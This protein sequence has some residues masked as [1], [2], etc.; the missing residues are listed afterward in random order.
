MSKDK[1]KSPVLTIDL[2]MIDSSGI[3]TYLK[4]LIPQIIE[5]LPEASFN[6]LGKYKVI[7]KH[8][9]LKYNRNITLIQTGAPIYSLLEQIEIPKKIP[10]NTS[11]F[12]SPHYNIPLLYKGKLLVTVHDLFHLAMRQMVPGI[13]KKNYAKIMFAKVSSKADAI[14]CISEFTKRELVRFTHCQE[15]KIHLIY[16]GTNKSNNIAQECSPYP[17][18]YLLFVGNVKPNKNL[19]NLIRS[20]EIVKNIIP[21]DL[22][23]VGKKEGFITGDEYVF[24]K[25][26][27]LGSRIRFTGYIDDATLIQYYR[28]ATALVFPS[29]YEGFGL[30]PLEAMACDCPVIVSN[31]ASLPEVC[32]DAALY[33]DPFNCEDITTKILDIINDQKLR[34][35]LAFNGKRRISLFKWEECAKKTL[36][37]IETILTEEN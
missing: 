7:E 27:E 21:H 13:H 5:Y 11:L 36:A 28:H 23:I 32:G 14:I 19:V 10:K 15:E 8:I 6:L 3:G 1:F 29:I 34:E 16:N 20:F 4:N 33:C 12:W 26:A 24:K 31:K 9:D 35:T 18:P 2:R 37:I 17:R 30:P 22:V 25:A